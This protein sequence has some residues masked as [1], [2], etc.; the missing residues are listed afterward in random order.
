M[1]Q[2]LELSYLK[3]KNDIVCSVITIQEGFPMLV[4]GEADGLIYKLFAVQSA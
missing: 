4:V 3:L 2:L 1:L